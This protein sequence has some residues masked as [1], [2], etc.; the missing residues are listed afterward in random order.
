MLIKSITITAISLI[1]FSSYATD[2]GVNLEWDTKNRHDAMASMSS[3]DT[4]FVDMI[5]SGEIKE[6]YIKE[7]M[8][9]D[10]GISFINFVIEAKN[11]AKVREKIAT[12]PLYQ[13]KIVKI[14]SIVPLGSKWLDN[15]PTY[16]NY[17]LSFYWNKSMDVTE[18]NRILGIDLQRVVA[19]TQAGLVTSS[20]IHTQDDGSGNP[21]PVYLISVLAN[22]ESHALELSK[23]FESVIKG[24]VDVDVKYLGRKL[25]LDQK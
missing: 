16:G 2:F 17:A 11:E 12:L 18:L 4:S 6:V 3:Q 1:I 19:L 15:T 24:H 9:G 13:K 25:N 8:I 5:K 7:K 14:T 22:D 10:R 23:Q 21:K 20:Y